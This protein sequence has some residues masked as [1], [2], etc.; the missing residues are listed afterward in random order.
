MSNSLGDRG[1]G[2][3]L[4]R[5]M[6]AAD[7]CQ[8]TPGGYRL[9]FTRSDRMLAFVLKAM[10]ADSSAPRLQVTID[11]K[12]SFWVEVATAIPQPRASGT[13]VVA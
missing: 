8:K 12:E 5:L 1:I 10:D 9:R 11:G 4:S 7:V 13:P 2:E 6:G 3:L